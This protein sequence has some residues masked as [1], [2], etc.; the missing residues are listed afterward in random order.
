M[1]K[2]LKLILAMLL[3]SVF[4]EV[5]A[6]HVSSVND[7]VFLD[8]SYPVIFVVN[9]TE[10]REP[11][12]TML[13]DSVAAAMERMGSNGVV[14]GRAAASPEGPYW[15]NER[16]ANGRR[17]V[18]VRFLNDLGVDA[19]RIE[20]NTVI[21][22]Y[23]LLLEMLRRDGD[24]QYER[25]KRIV[26]AGNGDC[27]RIK[28]NLQLLAGGRVWDRLVKDYF[29]RLRATRIMVWRNTQF[30]QAPQMQLRLQPSVPDV[31]PEIQLG[32]LQPLM[33]IREKRREMLSLKTNLLGWGL[34]LPQY[35]G[36]CPI[37]NFALEYYPKH[38]HFTY[39]FSL[40]CPWWVGNTTNHKYMEVRNYQ[41]E[42]RYYFR[43]S[44]RSYTEGGAAF[45]GWYA[46][47]YV[48]NGLYQIGFSAK[49]GWIGEALGGGLGFGYVLPISRN[50]H[51]RLEFGAQFGYFTT[52]YDP[53]VY[54][55]PLFHGGEI[56]GLYY[57]DTHLYR[58]NFVKRQHRY[59]WMGPTR[60]DI[61]LSYDLLYRRK[62]SK[63]PSFS[64]WEKGD[65]R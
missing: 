25:V 61:T 2:S 26:E 52:W 57:Y 62:Y 50:Q 59:T 17:D 43:N 56:D 31:L 55:K 15:N 21:E 4:A 46:Q 44:D 20:F 35:G 8:N 45:K 10:L 12:R 30:L 53:F 64:M 33:P 47:A 39:G 58:D 19:D 18:V 37:P 36:W 22:D 65:G 24:T 5:R 13:A 29:P 32:S 23:D 9:R 1:L 40:D 60:V 54:G 27:L 51:W 11:Y 42:S 49:K 38:G 16:L 63:R 7:S 48:Q 14:I 3:I 41:F 34:Q 28:A 6:Q